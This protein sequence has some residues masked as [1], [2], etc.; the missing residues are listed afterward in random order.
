MSEKPSDRAIIE[1]RVLRLERKL[2]ALIAVIPYG[3]VTN[4]EWLQKRLNEADI[5]F[6]ELMGED[7]P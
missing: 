5:D 4:P 7:T 3:S 2:S 6:D 1:A